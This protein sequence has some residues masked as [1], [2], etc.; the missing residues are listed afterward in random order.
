MAELVYKYSDGGRKQY[1]KGTAS[2]CVTRAISI[3][4]GMDYKEC[5]K[6]IK[7][8]V[9]YTPRNGIRHDDTKKIM[10]A[11]GGVWH[12]L[13]AIGTGCRHH[14][15]GGEIPMDKKIIC[16]LSGHVT[17][18][19]NGVNYDVFNPSRGGTRCVYG[20]WDFKS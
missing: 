12:P 8:V 19:V 17:A 5:Y 6:R 2:D 16:S 11:F 20:Y 18:V 14:L 13:M 9:G 7:S 1:F 15:M 3:V 4:C 10:S